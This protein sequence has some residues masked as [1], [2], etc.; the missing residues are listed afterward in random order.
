MLSA[1]KIK[2]PSCGKHVMKKVL[3]VTEGKCNNCGYHIAGSISS[4][5]KKVLP[6]K[7]LG[8]AALA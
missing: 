5:V 7:D 2:C 3:L 1:E 4:F 6:S 8:P